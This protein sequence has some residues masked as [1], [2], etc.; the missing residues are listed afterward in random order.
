MATGTLTHYNSFL[1]KV[2]SKL[3]DLSNGGDKIKVA[4]CNSSYTPDRDAHDFFDDLTN[5][6]TGTGYT[7]GGLLLASRLRRR[8]RAEERVSE[9]LRSAT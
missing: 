2:L 6:V 9:R 3:I 4:L 1:V 7:A 8:G 5:E